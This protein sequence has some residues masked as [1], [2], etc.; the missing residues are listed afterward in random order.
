MSKKIKVFAIAAAALVLVFALIVAGLSIYVSK[1]SDEYK[2]YITQ[3]IEEQTGLV[4]HLDG[5]LS[6]SVFPWLGLETEAIAVEN[7][8]AFKAEGANMFSASKL[9]IELKLL[10]LLQGSFEVGDVRI[11]DL[12]LLLIKSSQGVGNW[13]IGKQATLDTA[14]QSE[15]A[16][17]AEQAVE[18]AQPDAAPQQDANQ[19]L[20]DFSKYSIGSVSLENAEIT[21]IDLQNNKEFKFTGMNLESSN[22]ALGEDVS[23]K[24][25]TAISS[26]SPE[27]AAKVDLK[28]VL[29]MTSLEK[30]EV[31]S[32][33]AKINSQAG[34]LGKGELALDAILSKNGAELALTQFD[35]TFLGTKMNI[36]GEANLEHFTFNGPLAIDANPKEILNILG[37]KMETADAS[38]LTSFKLKANLNSKQKNEIAMNNIQ[39]NLDK[40]AI[41]GELLIKSAPSLAVAGNLALDVLNADAYMPSAGEGANSGASGGS[42]QSVASTVAPTVAPTVESA[43]EKPANGAASGSSSGSSSG[44]ASSGIDLDVG[45]SLGKLTLTGMQIQ[46]I[47]TRLDA[48]NK[49]FSLKPLSF[50][51]AE[52]AFNGAVVADLAQKT[53]R[54]QLQMESKS[55]DIEKL[56]QA[57]NGKSSLSGKADLSVNV[58]GSGDA[59]P[60]LSR[61]LGGKVSVSGSGA[62]NNFR[63]PK[64]NLTAVPGVK[65]VDVVNAKIQRFSASFNGAGGVFTNN[66]LIFNS[67]IANGTGQGSINLGASSLNYQVM[68]KTAKL[69]LPIAI[70]GPFSSLSYALD[71]QAMI[72]DPENLQEGVNQLM[73]HKGKDIEKGIGKGLQK[74]FGN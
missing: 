71:A 24:L 7:S 42:S 59:W 63:L 73:K 3:F 70:S 65:P 23:F 30:F 16:A 46:N 44:A 45:L 61:S 72:S 25:E 38:A 10:P 22:I 31:K 48:K 17:Q 49:V 26:K 39:A 27:I 34:L 29:N 33:N 60:V 51:F 20:Q 15:Q 28:S 68:L 50:N 36:S 14:N 18:T 43:G 52:S 64:I 53:P 66:D 54:L 62:L 41:S 32:L 21:Y 47:K 37:K 69:N 4:V 58:N 13:E 57:L 40:T 19:A 8:A 74:I 56:L 11:S 2:A 55:M 9:G 12:K 67:D 35:L 1:H 5:A 6:V